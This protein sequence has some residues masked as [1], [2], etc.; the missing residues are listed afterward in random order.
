MV[1]QLGLVVNL[2]SREAIHLGCLFFLSCL[3]GPTRMA[4]TEVEPGTAGRTCDHNQA[5][6]CFQLFLI[7][8]HLCFGQ[9]SRIGY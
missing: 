4:Y 9:R 5:L 6:P 2:Q 1:N 7:L 3:D 8:F